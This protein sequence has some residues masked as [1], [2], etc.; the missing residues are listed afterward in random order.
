MQEIKIEIL[1][2]E[3]FQFRKQIKNPSWF[4]LENRMWNDQQFFY[5][6]A[7]E[8]WIWVCI[9]SIAS[10][11]Q[12]STL[13]VGLDWLSQN[14]Q[15]KPEIIQ[16]SL[17]KLRDNNCLEYT[18][19]TRNVRVPVCSATEQ[20]ITRQ[21]ITKQ[22]TSID[23]DAK[24][25]TSLKLGSSY[26]R[27]ISEYVKAYQARYKARPPI[28]G[29]TQGLVKN[30]LSTIPED[31]A[32][33][34]VQAFLQMNDPWFVKKAHDFSTFYANLTKVS[35]ALQTGIDLGAPEKERSFAEVWAEEEE[36]RRHKNGS[37]LVRN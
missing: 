20:N 16:S 11:K 12:T 25:R 5:F 34:L 1:N 29:K 37:E 21:N 28:D 33:D 36:K 23:A 14:S 22:N 7:E 4:R 19:H 15:V 35:V 6:T 8:R 3:K 17:K 32:C 30:I 9:L 2:W 18:L 24:R 10:Q 13:L 27:L 31:Q 26:S